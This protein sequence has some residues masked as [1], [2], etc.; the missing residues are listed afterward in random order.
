VDKGHLELMEDTKNEPYKTK[1]YTQNTK[2]KKP[3]QALK[4]K[5]KQTFL[6]LHKCISNGKPDRCKN[7]IVMVGMTHHP[8][9]I[10][11][12]YVE[13]KLFNFPLHLSPPTCASFL[14]FFPPFIT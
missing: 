10:F 13:P 2:M 8:D 9:L 5:N 11:D 12:S 1:G 3:K 6:P 4:I 14:R 7:A